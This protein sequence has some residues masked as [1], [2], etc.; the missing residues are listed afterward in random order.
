MILFMVAIGPVI[1]GFCKQVAVSNWDMAL[2]PLK[3]MKVF[4]RFIDH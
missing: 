4:Y 3:E 2:N 1:S